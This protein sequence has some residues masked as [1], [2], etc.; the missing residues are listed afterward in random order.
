MDVTL[1]V[2]RQAGPGVAG[3][4]EMTTIKPVPGSSSSA[5]RQT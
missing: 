1:R 3:G 2:W 5:S 4:F